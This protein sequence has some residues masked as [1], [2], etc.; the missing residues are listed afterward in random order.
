M[1]AG[2]QIK[3]VTAGGA[4][5][6]LPPELPWQFHP[7]VV[8]PLIEVDGPD[9]EDAALGLLRGMLGE[10]GF[11]RF[12]EAVDRGDIGAEDFGPLVGDI[13]TRYGL[14]VR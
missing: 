5:Y 6:L 14:E 7:L 12:L 4:I 13:Y 3:S 9:G 10:D 2:T 1:A 8:Q 11:R